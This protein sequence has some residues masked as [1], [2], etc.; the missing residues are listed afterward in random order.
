MKTRN[1]TTPES[2]Q[3]LFK[4]MSITNGI[5]YL[6]GQPLSLDDVTLDH[7]VPK[8]LGGSNDHDNKLPTHS[9][10]NKMKADMT[11]EQFILQC[12]QIVNNAIRSMVYSE[13]HNQLSNYK[14]RQS[15]NQ[16]SNDKT[17][18][19]TPRNPYPTRNVPRGIEETNSRE[20]GK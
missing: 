14:N 12:S 4:L 7:I 20:N 2:K 18:N 6:C 17:K 13:M 19:K 10:C 11:Y 1:S 16:S 15:N 5:C 8:S 3:R 9:I